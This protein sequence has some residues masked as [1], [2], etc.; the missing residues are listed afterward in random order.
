MSFFQLVT[1]V[2]QDSAARL[3]PLERTK[4]NLITRVREQIVLA[5]DAAYAPMHKK[6]IKHADGTIS[7]MEVP[8]RVK[9]WW[10]PKSD[11]SIELIVRVGARKLE[12][13]K[14]KDAISLKSFDDLVPT[15]TAL[16]AAVQGG[17]FDALL[18]RE[19]TDPAHQQW[20]RP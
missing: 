18:S 9:R 10:Y 19:G 14:G 4:L 12:L 2:K 17:E 5:E 8:R 3:S 11:G 13:A 1:L 15:L 16:I 20:T 7:V 6:R